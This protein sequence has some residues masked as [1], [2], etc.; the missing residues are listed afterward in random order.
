VQVY[1]CE[2]NT[3]SVLTLCT[4][5]YVKEYASLYKPFN[6]EKWAKKLDIARYFKDTTEHYI[7]RLKANMLK[8]FEQDIWRQL[9]ASTSTE[10]IHLL[11][12]DIKKQALNRFEILERGEY[13]ENS[14]TTSRSNYII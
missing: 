4:K 3:L 13:N 2:S 6:E 14:E 9:N 12:F 1:H 10:G 11:L 5:A 8:D 7:K